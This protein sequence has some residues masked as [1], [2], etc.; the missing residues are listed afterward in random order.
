M[1]IWVICCLLVATMGPLLWRAIEKSGLLDIRLTMET[2]NAPGTGAGNLA[3]LFT[4]EVLY[5]S[6]DI[7]RWATSQSLDPNLVATT[8]QIESCGHPSISS[9]SGARGLFQVM[10]YHFADGEDPLDPE[11][12]AVRGLGMLAD[13][14]ERADDNVGRAMACYNGGPST[15]TQRYDAW[16]QEA[17]YYYI[18]ATGIYED[19]VAGN[20]HSA[21]LDRWL[22][23]GG[24]SLCRRAADALGME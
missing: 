8:M 12:N 16:A 3:P 4:R 20:N 10:P 9:P 24:A 23:A 1:P 14:L 22:A 6:N 21:T 17:R 2:S 18:W 11:T 5:W 7:D 15:L 19:A 13:C